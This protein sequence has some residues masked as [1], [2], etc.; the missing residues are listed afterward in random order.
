MVKDDI[1]LNEKVNISEY[2]HALKSLIKQEQIH[3]V[4]VTKKVSKM[5]LL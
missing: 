2:N 3:T 1:I 5:M 4:F